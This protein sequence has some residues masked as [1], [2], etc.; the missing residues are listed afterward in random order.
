MIRKICEAD[1]EAFLRMSADFY[2]SAAVSH[3]VP[4]AYHA[5][6]FDELMRSDAYA[7]GY[8]VEAD[9]KPV[10]FALTAKT[11]SRE[12][13]GAVLWLEEVYILEG[14]RSRGLGKE[15]FAFIEE[16]ARRKGIAR[17]RLE[18]APDNVRARALYKKLG[19]VPLEYD[20]MLME[21]RGGIKGE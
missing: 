16:H 18:V 2:A 5:D 3:P 17:I 7:E 1:R 10:G 15:Y 19:Y 8:M 9:G 20:Q 12:A 13:G 11:Y 21:L 6:A 14:Y 4:A